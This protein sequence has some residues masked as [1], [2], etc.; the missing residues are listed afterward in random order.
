[1]TE[2]IPLI[3][4]KP[5][6]VAEVISIAGGRMAIKRLADLGLTPG[7]KI[8]VLRKAPLFGPVEIEARGSKL[9][10]GRGLASKILVKLETK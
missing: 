1:M 2:N 5:G 9:V 10:L 6:E 7:T 4:L 8:K 3:K